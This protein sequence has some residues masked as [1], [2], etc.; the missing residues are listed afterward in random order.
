[1]KMM[2]SILSIMET[3][4]Q[5]NINGH[6]IAEILLLRHQKNLEISFIIPQVLLI[7]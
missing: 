6:S 4:E 3:M 5:Q 7:L 1:M 2:I